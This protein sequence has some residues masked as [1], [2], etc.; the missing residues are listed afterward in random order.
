MRSTNLAFSLG[1]L[2]V[3]GAFDV[4]GGVIR[5][6]FVQLNTPDAMRGRVTAVQSVFTTTSNELGSTYATS[7]GG[8]GLRREEK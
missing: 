2:L 5:N 3:M 8:P 6:G 4:V 1:A 7:V